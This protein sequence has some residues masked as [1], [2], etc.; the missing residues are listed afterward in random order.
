[1]ENLNI[2]V[3]GCT[4]NSD[5][6]IENEINKLLANIQSNLLRKFFPAPEYPDFESIVIEFF[7]TNF[8]I[9]KGNRSFV[10]RPIF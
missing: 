4:K 8:F 1:M 7:L 9:N 5:K 3:C 10:F 2:V 6:Y